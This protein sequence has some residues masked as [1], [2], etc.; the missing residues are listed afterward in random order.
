MKKYA[1]KEFPKGTRL[2][3]INIDIELFDDSFNDNLLDVRTSIDK[4]SKDTLFLK[5][6][7]TENKSTLVQATAIWSKD[8]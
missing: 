8:I 7:I 2:L 4:K 6:I 3:S 5:T 1:K